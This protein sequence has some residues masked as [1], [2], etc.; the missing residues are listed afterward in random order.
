MLAHASSPN[1]PPPSHIGIEKEPTDR[2]RLQMPLDFADSLSL[3][4]P[5]ELERL[6]CCVERARSLLESPSPECRH[7]AVGNR[8][9]GSA[10]WVVSRVVLLTVPQWG[11]LV[12]C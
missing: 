2:P 4:M 8:L 11:D 7:Q 5:Q 1:V 6:G 10:Q 3:D 12:P 9:V